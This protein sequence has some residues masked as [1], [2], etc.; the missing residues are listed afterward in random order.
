MRKS[1]NDS[2]VS[3]DNGVI[4]AERVTVNERKT[5]SY[6]SPRSTTVSALKNDC[7][8]IEKEKEMELERKAAHVALT[9]RVL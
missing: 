9:K 3:S 7:R 2:N 4:N 5:K 6:Y 8:R 1:R